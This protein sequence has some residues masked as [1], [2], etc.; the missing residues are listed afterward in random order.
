MPYSYGPAT[1]LRSTCRSSVP[2]VTPARPFVTPTDVVR[3]V[4]ALSAAD[5]RQ[6]TREPLSRGLYSVPQTAAAVFGRDRRFQRPGHPPVDAVTCRPIP[7]PGFKPDR[8]LSI[9][10]E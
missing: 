9:G 3:A 8:R 7:V 10:A 2:A 1:F 5:V 4:A 6:A